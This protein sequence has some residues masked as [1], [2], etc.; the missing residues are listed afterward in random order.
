MLKEEVNQAE[1]IKK[2]KSTI[3]ALKKMDAKKKTAIYH[4]D[5]FDFV[6]D[7]SSS[8]YEYAEDVDDVSKIR[9]QFTATAAGQQKGSR[10]NAPN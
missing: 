7:Y 8:D 5:Q 9:K 4:P 3:K 10:N 1:R 2:K 6:N